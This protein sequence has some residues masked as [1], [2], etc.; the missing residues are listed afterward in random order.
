M[1]LLMSSMMLMVMTL[2]V[3]SMMLLMMMTLLMSSMGGTMQAPPA[4]GHHPLGTG[5]TSEHCA[6]DLV[7]IL[8]DTL[9]LT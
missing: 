9:R 7:V 1:T 2:L 8:M 3:C 6:L 4:W 5:N